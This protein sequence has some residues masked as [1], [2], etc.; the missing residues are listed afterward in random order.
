MAPGVA[1]ATASLAA[2]EQ[3]RFSGWSEPVNLGPAVNSAVE[4]LAPAISRDGLS[5]Y[6]GS[7][8]P[9]TGTSLD[10]WVSRRA[11]TTSP[12]G[13]ASKLGAPVNMAPPVTDNGAALS[14][15]GHLLFFQ[16]NRPG[17][18]GATDLY[19]S[20][21]RDHRDDFGWEAPVN[22]GPAI[23]SAF[24]EGGTAYFEDENGVVTLYFQS[25]RPGG[26]GGNDIYTSTRMADGTFGAPIHVPELSSPANDQRVTVR[27]DGL[28]LYLA[29]NRSGTLGGQ[30]IWVSTRGS[31]SEPWSA[32]VNLG[33][34]INTVNFDAGPALS[35]DGTTLYFH[36]AWRPGTVGEEGRF[37]IWMS[38]RT[39][40]TG[41]PEK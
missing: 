20:R 39:R 35:F 10:L 29:S 21:R 25:N 38:T 23:N 13:A 15:D 27:R 1:G 3:P 22:L 33:P 9:A 36:A 6:F 30:D 2:E 31:T 5:L 14:R 11:S 12:W 24:G 18:S 16:S 4:D 34:V 8:R 17:G 41:P 28:E 37:D 7:S 19:V 26:L 40:L 32:P